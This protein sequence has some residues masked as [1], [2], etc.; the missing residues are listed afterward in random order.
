MVYLKSILRELVRGLYG[1]LVRGACADFVGGLCGDLGGL[2]GEPRIQLTLRH[3]SW[4]TLLWLT[5]LI[6]FCIIFRSRSHFLWNMLHETTEIHKYMKDTWILCVWLDM[7]CLYQF[8]QVIFYPGIMW[9][10]WIFHRFDFMKWSRS[11]IMRLKMRFRHVL[12]H[13]V[14]VSNFSSPCWP[15]LIRLGPIFQRT[16][17][18]ESCKLMRMW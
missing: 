9:L 3:R 2:C 4:K 15:D 5:N 7:S 12:Q 10:G 6:L 16:G 13:M 8:S 17:A 1:G 14:S 18:I 11:K